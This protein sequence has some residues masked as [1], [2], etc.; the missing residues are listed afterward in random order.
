[1]SSVESLRGRLVRLGFLDRECANEP[2]YTR[3]SCACGC[4]VYTCKRYAE[5]LE[6]CPRCDTPFDGESAPQ[7]AS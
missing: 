1:M 5:P 3:Q 4:V 7:V 2:G 6:L